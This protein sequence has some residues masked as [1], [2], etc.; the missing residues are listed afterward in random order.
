MKFHLLNSEEPPKEG[1]TIKAE[2]GA[3]IPN[4]KL[5]FSVAVF[6]LVDLSALIFC[7][8]CQQ[9]PKFDKR[10]LS[11]LANGQEFLTEDWDE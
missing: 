1:V 9:A 10:Y 11:A 3:E 8:K 7:K 5:I 6:E 4:A 2:C